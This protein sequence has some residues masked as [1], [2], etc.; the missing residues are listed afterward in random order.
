VRVEKLAEWLGKVLL[1]SVSLMAM[2]MGFKT[3]INFS[4]GLKE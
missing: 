2:I 4:K 3:V 1:K